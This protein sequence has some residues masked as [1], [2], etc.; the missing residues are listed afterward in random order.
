MF[1]PILIFFSAI[2]ISLTAAYFSIIGLATMFPGSKEAIIIMGS[3]LE[4]GKLVAAVWLHKN[5]HTAFGFIRSYLLIAVIILT[6]ITSMGIFGFLSRSHVEHGASI[7]KETAMIAQIESKISRE[8]DF[9]NRKEQ[10]ISSLKDNQISS[11]SND[12]STITSLEERISKIKEESEVSILRNKD[13]ITSYNL[14]LSELDKSLEE[15]KQSGLFSNNKKYKELLESQKEERLSLSERKLNADQNIESI[16][17]QTDGSISKTREQIDSIILNENS[18]SISSNFP[19]TDTIRSAIESSY[20][21]IDLLESERFQFGAKLRALE[22][23]IGPIKYIAS[24]LQDWGGMNVDISE[25]IRIVIVILIF[26]FDP[27]AI[28]L[29]IAA[30]M[31][32][33]SIKKE[34]LPTDVKEIRGKLLEELQEYIDEG[35]IAEHFIEKANK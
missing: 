19:Q 25:S 34:E 2:S 12:S 31:S 4:I 13:L 10:E 14:R 28:L 17:K 32:Y 9:I 33:S 6:G 29:L 3:V 35:G 15:S 7:D 21:K 1:F 5:W 30:T 27:L 16:I 26:V 23:E 8:K 22:V 11:T 20:D 18:T 24:A